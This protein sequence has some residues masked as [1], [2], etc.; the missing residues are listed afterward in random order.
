MYVQ[1]SRFF[2]FFNVIL[3][4]HSSSLSFINDSMKDFPTCN[5]PEPPYLIRTTSPQVAHLVVTEAQVEYGGRGWLVWRVVESLSPLHP[6]QLHRHVALYMDATHFREGSPWYQGS[7][8]TLE[9]KLSPD[10]LVFNLHDKTSTLAGHQ[11]LL[12]P[13]AST[14]PPAW[15]D[16]MKYIASMAF[17]A[18]F[19]PSRRG[20]VPIKGT[21]AC[22]LVF[23]AWHHHSF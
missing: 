16:Q 15:W 21:T 23:P 17:Q 22:K 4:S 14:V 2:I 1:L 12:A 8:D 13:Y 10:S 20:T 7:I 5:N 19:K 3:S 11:R 9:H 18:C 6:L